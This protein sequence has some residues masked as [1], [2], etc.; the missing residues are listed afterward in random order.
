VPLIIAVGFG[1]GA[2]I[3]VLAVAAEHYGP[4]FGKY[5][6][7]G[8]GAL[9]VPAVLAPFAIFAGWSWV[10][11]RGGRALELAVFVLG[12]HFG[13]GMISPLDATLFPSAPD[14]TIVDALPGFLLSGALFVLPAALLAA[15]AY[16]VARRTEGWAFS[17]VVLIAI[18]IGAELAG[19]F[20]GGL[21]LIAGVALSAVE[22]W[23]ARTALITAS[24]FVAMVL[25]A[26]LTYLTLLLTL[27]AS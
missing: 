19:L 21:G 7:F 24:L 4:T 18:V 9:I 2:L 17:L 23:P 12:L 16:W 10:R 15:G 27:P 25:L 8:N 5:A 1:S 14:V 6:L 20:G 26:N 11:R 13:I 3:A 22:R